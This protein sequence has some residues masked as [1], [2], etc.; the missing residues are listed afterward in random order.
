LSWHTEATVIGFRP[1]KHTPRG[2]TSADKYTVRFEQG[3]EL[4]FFE[5]QLIATEE[6]RKGA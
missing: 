5:I 6:Q 2:V 3:A 1:N 4:E